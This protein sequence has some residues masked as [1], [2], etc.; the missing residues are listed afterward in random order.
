MSG[1]DEGKRGLGPPE[2]ILDEQGKDIRVSSKKKLSD[3]L[4]RRTRGGSETYTPP[5]QGAGDYTYMPPR[6]NTYPIEPEYSE[7]GAGAETRLPGQFASDEDL[8]RLSLSG[9][10]DLRSA[11]SIQPSA[12]ENSAAPNGNEVND[13]LET[14]DIVQSSVLSQN[15]FTSGDKFTAKSY[16]EAAPRKPTGKTPGPNDGSVF[17]EMRQRAIETMLKA[18]GEGRD[19]VERFGFKAT[20]LLLPFKGVDEGVVKVAS[21]AELRVGADREKFIAPGGGLDG[22]DNPS[23]DTIYD[24]SFGKDGSGDTKDTQPAQYNDRSF[25]QLNNFLQQFSGKGT[26]STVLLALIA[27]GALFVGVS[28]VSLIISIIVNKLPRPDPKTSSL[29]LGS[30]R[31]PAFGKFLFN[32]DSDSG[33]LDFFAVIGNL[34]AKLIGVMQPYEGIP[35]VSYFLAALEGAL[36]IIGVDTSAFAGGGVGGFLLALGRSIV[37]IAINFGTAPSYYLVL[38]REIARDLYYMSEKFSSK[39]E[40][41]LLG[42]FDAIREMKIV[43]FVDTCA[44]LGIVNGVAREASAS[45]E[46]DAPLEKEV[47]GAATPAPAGLETNYASV[48]QARVSRSREVEGSKR[49]SW[50]HISLGYTRTELVTKESLRAFGHYHVNGG[51]ESGA[52]ALRRLRAKKVFADSGRIDPATREY[53][54]TLLDAEYMP[55]Y[56]HDIRTNEI[57]SFHA[58]LSSLSDSFTANYTAT[59][60]FGRMDP[61]QT[62]K[63]TTRSISFNFTVVATSPEDHDNMWYSINK[64]VNMLYPQWSKGEDVSDDQNKFTQPF[65]QT[66]AASPLIRVRIGD[67]IHSNYSRFALGRIFGLD[68]EDAKIGGAGGTAATELK[69]PAPGIDTDIKSISKK[70]ASDE[71]S[72]LG[73]AGVKLYVPSTENLNDS[74]PDIGAPPDNSLVKTFAENSN[75]LLFPRLCSVRPGRYRTYSVYGDAIGKSNPNRERLKEESP[76]KI[77]GVVPPESARRAKVSEYVVQLDAPIV[78]KKLFGE[79]IEHSFIT[80]TQ[81]DIIGFPGVNYAAAVGILPLKPTPPGPSPVQTFLDPATNPVVRS[82]EQGSGGR[83]LAG[84]IS[85]LGVE[86]GSTDTPWTVERGSRAPNIV[87]LSVSFLPI[88]DIPMGLAAD[89]TARAVAYPVGGITR[90]RHMPDAYERDR[91]I[92]ESLAKK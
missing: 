22:L 46:P 42:I 2:F 8:E 88:H 36:S 76:G 37:N 4:S 27:Y 44:R 56:F 74:N 9:Y 70:M 52:T 15:R 10:P 40:A 85:G 34:V 31:G 11:V 20:S 7:T 81:D 19:G 83:G 67:V 32:S 18:S 53:H 6:P 71:E 39:I 72:A 12:R 49:L 16:R 33:F 38:I 17:E 66:V 55:F 63:N 78:I 26:L 64:L 48:A 43:R 57:L 59:E 28:L 3:Y 77:V 29:P 84:F 82:F 60:G 86:Y 89:G 35:L 14:R 5:L 54:E 75:L 91:L 25:G 80:C 51:K 45:T 13:S 50:S 1:N 30:E 73:A 65:S 24:G 68:Q 23:T 47:P 87:T 41:S 58:F 79:D 69:D 90:L 61:I 92:A 21:S 62:Y